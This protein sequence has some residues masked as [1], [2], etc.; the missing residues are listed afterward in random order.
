MS[1]RRFDETFKRKVIQEYEAGGISCYCLGKKYGVDAKCVRSWCRLYKQYGEDYLT[2]DHSN[3]NYSAEFKQQVVNSY[4]EGGKTYQS[5][6][7]DFGILAPTTVKK[8]V[9]MYNNHE[10][11]K[12]SR[13]EGLVE[14]VKKNTRKTTLEERIEIVE[15]CIGCNYNY[16]LAAKEF[17]VSYGQVYTW[18]Q[19]YNAG[20]A[21][22]L[23]DRRGKLKAPETIT[24]Q[25]RLQ[26]E[27][28][29]LRAENK[30]QQ[31]EID[32]L[33]KLEE[34]ERRRF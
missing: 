24:E 34:I 28:R 14:M 33:K 15:Y 10:E 1:R 30:K 25:E 32:F 2:D 11:L 20:G 21:D 12:N 26:I 13:P 8:W 23:L 4:L 16:A 3:L 5:V 19:K 27:I 22:N 9:M 17:D 31:M 18:V 6:A 7:A 29:M